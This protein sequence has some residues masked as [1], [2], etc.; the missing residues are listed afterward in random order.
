[1][2]SHN[3]CNISKIN[4][5]I[6]LNVKL[7]KSTTQWVLNDEQVRFSGNAPYSNLSFTKTNTKAW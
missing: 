6:N 2:K 4:Y 7:V 1:M 5:K 3:V